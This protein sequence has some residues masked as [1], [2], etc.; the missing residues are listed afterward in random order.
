[1]GI[2]QPL[3]IGVMRESDGMVYAAAFPYLRGNPEDNT[4]TEHLLFNYGM[5][6]GDSAYCHA[7]LSTLESQGIDWL[8][9]ISPQM[10]MDYY[11]NQYSYYFRLDRIEKTTESNGQE[12]RK[13]Y[14]SAHDRRTREETP[15]THEIINLP[16]AVTW[17]E[18][19]GAVD[20]YPFLAFEA[21][22]N[23]PYWAPR[24]EDAYSY[25]LEKCYIDEKLLNSRASTTGIS[26]LQKTSSKMDANTLYDLSGRRIKGQPQ[27]GV[28]IQ[29]GKKY[30][31]K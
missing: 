15:S 19:V 5:H 20:G 14:F 18:G 11:G 2:K 8:T 6:Q 16:E 13:Y 9:S 1:M 25:K 7:I 24:I 30:V 28:Y 17:V 4:L 10:G 27:K 29:G 23:W 31:R 26:S 12:L 3:L 21:G 22:E